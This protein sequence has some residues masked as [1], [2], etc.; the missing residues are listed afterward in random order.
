MSRRETREA[1][2]KLI[3]ETELCGEINELSVEQIKSE[4][5]QS[6]DAYFE[7]T[8]YGVQEH[9]KKLSDMIATYTGSF[10]YERLYKVDLSI[11]LLAVYEI[12]FTDIPNKV[13]VN[14]AVELAKAYSTEK[15]ASFINGI[16]ASII[17]NSNKEA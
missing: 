7:S 17:K 4:I 11:L 2:F 16:L 13:S 5:D 14:E 15:S 9:H 12:M 6:D 3:Y 8:F 1:V 10:A